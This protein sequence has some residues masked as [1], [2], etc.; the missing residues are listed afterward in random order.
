MLT[1]LVHFPHWQAH[2]LVID[3]PPG[4]P[5]AVVENGRVGDHTPTAAHHGVETGMRLALA[6]YLC[7]NLIVMPA[8][9]QRSARSFH[10]VLTALDQVGPQVH[11]LTPGTAWMPADPLIKWHG[12]APS[13]VET[14]INTISEYTGSDCQVGIGPGLV[15]AWVSLKSE[16][17]LPDD[18]TDK[19]IANFPLAH[20]THLYPPAAPTLEETI[21]Q[22]KDLGVV[23]IAQ[24]QNLGLATLRSRYPQAANF[25]TTVLDSSQTPTSVTITPAKTLAREITFPNAVTDTDHAVGQLKQISQNLVHACMGQ[26]LSARQLKISAHIQTPNGVIT[27]QRNWALIEVITT[28]DLVDRVRWQLQGWVSEI[29]T[30]P[31]TATDFTDLP[32]GVT[33]VRLEA[34]E[35]MPLADIS[36]HLWDQDTDTRARAHAGAYRLQ[37]LLGQDQV[38]CV[39]VEPGYDPR[40]RVQHY[41]W[42]SPAP[43]AAWENHQG[44]GKN[45][46]LPTYRP[47]Q[48]W[49]GAVELPAPST[50]LDHP[51]PVELMGEGGQTVEVKPNGNLTTTPTRLGLP[52]EEEAERGSEVKIIQAFYPHNHP[53]ERYH[54]ITEVA[55]PWPVMGPWWRQ[56]NS[57]KVWLQV[58]VESGPPILL[59]WEKPRW[60]LHAVWF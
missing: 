9:P 43:Q 47:E 50:V 11:A 18:P 42:G 26:Q 24:A 15:G 12:D 21:A 59:A 39:N 31:Q 23:T 35:L 56:K 19:H 45:A 28:R 17:L 44:A 57:G 3:T 34:C 38:T 36:A 16:T 27:R 14:I 51:V 53:G 30:G 32:T 41:Q 2:A 46:H 33:S 22:L 54:P 60:W 40:S 37:A 49:K 1:A 4:A 7:P 13:A 25:F 20:L 58:H 5:A 6:R 29:Q 8:D 52:G 55:G 10:Q 48:R